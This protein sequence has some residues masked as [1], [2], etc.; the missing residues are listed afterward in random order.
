VVAYDVFVADCPARTTLDLVAD[1]W[2]MI[3]VVA[4]DRGPA[5]CRQLQE[6]AVD[7][8]KLATG[9]IEPQ[10]YGELVQHGRIIP[11]AEPAPA[12]QTA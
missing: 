6:A 9:P 5:R 7:V 12:A 3:A 8:V 10:M 11:W 2:S 1:T 4:R